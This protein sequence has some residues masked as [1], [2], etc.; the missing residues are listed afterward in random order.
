[1]P[2]RRR[3]PTHRTFLAIAAVAALLSAA[4]VSGPAGTGIALAHGAEAGSSAFTF[5]PTR[6]ATDA[7]PSGDNQGFSVESADFAHGFLDRQLLAQPLATLGHR[8][9]I[10]IG[11]YTAELVWPAFGAYADQPAPAWAI[12]GTVD[13][14]DLA[15]LK[16]LVDA[17]GWKVTIAVPVL[18]VINS[19]VTYDQ[20][21]AEVV[22]A[23]RTLG[24]RLE[25]VEIGNEYDLVTRLTPAQYYSV[26][27]T[28]Y[29]DIN[30]AIPDDHIRVDGPSAGSPSIPMLQQFVSAAAADQTIS[31]PRQEIHAVT[32]HHY[33]SGRCGLDIAGLMSAQ[34]YT[35]RQAA[36]DG[37]VASVNSLHDDMPVVLNETNSESGSGCTG[38]SNSYAASLWV[39]DYLLQ[40]T[41]AGIADLN[42]HT[43]TARVCNDY[44]TDSVGYTTSY[45]WY[46]AFCATDKTALNA[47][48]LSA[49][50]LYYGIWAFRQVPAGQF[51][52]LGGYPNDDLS[53]LR[54]YG[55]ESPDHTLTIILINVQD[56][57]S[58]TSTTDSI[59]VDLPASYHAAGSAVTLNSSA[60]GGFAST[61]ASAITLGG[62]R[63]VF[64]GSPPGPFD[65]TTL[66][67]DDGVARL[68]VAPGTAQIVTLPGVKLP[69]AVDI[70]GITTAGAGML[71]GGQTNP[72]TVSVANTTDAART[73]TATLQVPSGWQAGSVTQTVPALG[74]IDLTVPVTPPVEPTQATLTAQVSAPQVATYGNS[75][76][77]VITT[78]P[79]NAVPVALDGGTTTS[80]VLAGYTRVSP[81]DT[82]ATGDPFG[83]VGQV[84]SSRD[85]GFPDDL[86]RDLIASPTPATL[87]LAIPPGTHEVYLLVGDP[88]FAANRI[89]VSSSGHTLATTTEALPPNRYQ[90]IHF[91][92]DGGTTGQ[93]VDLTFS[94]GTANQFWV[95]N[96]LVVMP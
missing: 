28:Y 47:N 92:V 20:A 72:V 44:H 96:A 58:P 78:P 57:S 18:S 61:D 6:G 50:P 87:R 19:R 56:P 16:L 15:K 24:N 84:P 32:A 49:S 45:R 48:E 94:S 59:T 73:V 35:T 1:M 63:A 22:A 37:D 36:L 42:F 60:P 74:P 30:A 4:A 90:W 25:A 8:G 11:G 62:R 64:D 55:V 82:W 67:V 26:M 81:A 33:D 46:A 80:P 95:Y 53:Q 77:D 10:R 27:R 12:G 7:G 52:E 29:A 34:N 79:A 21:V 75:S 93:Q 89:I 5:T 71:T 3:N 91:P 70:T 23:H 41:Q 40:A 66:P 2:G 68:T 13:Q 17:T 85:R 88:S 43:S 9:T 86:R 51:V 83:W 69:G 39:L 31:D 76:L 65:H 14:S 54:A 38:V